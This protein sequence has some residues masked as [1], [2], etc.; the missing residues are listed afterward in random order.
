MCTPD[1]PQDT[2]E[3]EAEFAFRKAQEASKAAVRSN[4]PDKVAA[5]E[6]AWREQVRQELIRQMG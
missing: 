3:L 5:A 4:D 2:G 1:T 6:D